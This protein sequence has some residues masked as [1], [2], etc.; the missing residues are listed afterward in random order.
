MNLPQGI[1]N[2]AILNGC[3]I[4]IY[5]WRYKAVPLYLLLS[6]GCLS[7][8]YAVMIQLDWQAVAILASGSFVALLYL[9]YKKMLGLADCL[10]IPCCFAWIH[11]EEIPLFLVLCGVFG[12]VTSLF[13]RKYYKEKEYPFTPAILFSLSVLL[14]S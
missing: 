10:L 1:L 4:I 7:V 6:F 8:I 2:I 5:D 14:V 9:V 13:W 12:I 3:V 11:I